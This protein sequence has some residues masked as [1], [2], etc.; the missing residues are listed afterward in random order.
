MIPR[1]GMPRHPDR[2][3]SGTIFPGFRIREKKIPTLRKSPYIDGPEG[4]P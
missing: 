1:G 2:G 4:K 3:G